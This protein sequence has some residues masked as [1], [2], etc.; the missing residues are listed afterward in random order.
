MGRLCDRTR[1]GDRIRLG[2]SSRL[3]IGVGGRSG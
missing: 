1:L 2:D 3:V